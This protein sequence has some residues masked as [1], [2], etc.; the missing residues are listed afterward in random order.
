M[1]ELQKASRK[2]TTGYEVRRLVVGRAV[3]VVNG[4][5]EII[6]VDS[7]YTLCIV[8]GVEAGLQDEACVHF[9]HVEWGWDV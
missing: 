9:A 2:I 6:F 7:D 5:A 8:L 3:V 1:Q 4:F